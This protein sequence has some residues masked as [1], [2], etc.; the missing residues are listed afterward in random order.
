MGWLATLRDYLD[1][2]SPI[3]HH[4]AAGLSFDDYLELVTYAFNGNEYTAPVAFSQ[5][6]KKQEAIGPEFG[7]LV[8]GAYKRNTVVFGAIQ[9]RALVFSEVRFTWRNVK[10]HRLFTDQGLEPLERPAPGMTTGELLVRMEQDVSLAGNFFATTRYGGLRRLRPDWVT[11]VL[12]SNFEPDHP[13]LADDATVVGYIY[14]PGGV[15]AKV[16]PVEFGVNEVVHW[17]PIPD[18][19]ARFRGMSWLQPAIRE[20]LG[21]NA[22]TD[23]KNRFFENAATPN[24]I[25][26]APDMVKSAEQFKAFRDSIDEGHTGYRKAYKNL[27]LA[28]GSDV[29]VVGADLR[30]LDFKATQGAGE[31]R[32][33]LAGRVPAVILGNSEGL[34]GSSLNAGNYG[35]ARRLFADGFLRPQWRSA[36]A[37]LSQAVTPPDEMAELWYDESSVAFLRE[38]EADQA[39]INTK[40]SA[41]IRQLIDGGF[42]PDSAVNAI[43][44]NDLTQLVHTGALSVQL[45]P[46]GQ[47]Q[48]APAPDPADPEDADE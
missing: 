2:Y 26:V 7:T 30:Q 42:N 19:E 47:V 8:S 39:E 38:D 23:H 25:F 46:D 13:G 12:G 16:P 3:P 31:T 20:I 6:S 14:Q 5:P 34:S 9:A 1:P 40:K 24:M 44:R 21:D 17:S 41:A 15:G 22:A 4:R 11:L 29:K 43:D 27:Y 18:P 48:D 33:A 35:M 28:A 10:D 45:H 37:A 36:C 32:I